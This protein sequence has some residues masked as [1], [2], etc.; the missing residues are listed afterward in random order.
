MRYH[1]L[2]NH[3]DNSGITAA[4]VKAL[5]PRLLKLALPHKRDLGIGL[6]ALLVASGINLL[7]PY[8]I[9]QALNGELGLNLMNDL[10]R[11]SLLL[12]ALF[13]VQACMFYVR[14]L[15]F[16]TAGYKVVADLRETLY[17]AMMSQ[18]VAFF[19]RSRVGDLMSRLSN[20]TQLMQNAVT[21]NVSVAIRFLLQVVGGIAL[22]IWISGKLTLVILAT[23]PIVM[24]GGRYWG[25]RLAAASRRMQAELGEA[26]VVAEESL[27]AV[28]IVR[29]YA[30]EKHETSRYRAAIQRALESGIT[31]TGIAAVFSSSMVFVIH[32]SIAVVLWYGGSLVLAQ[33]LTLAD[34]TAFILY[35]VI[36]AA[37]LG[38]LLSAFDEF[39]HALGASERIFEV[40][41]SRPTIA[42]PVNP[43]SIHAER[44]PHVS[45][46]GVSFSYPS[47]P[48]VEV[49]HDITFDVARGKTIAIVGPSGAG[50]TSIASLIPR[51]YDPQHGSI[52]YCGV[53][54]RQLDPEQLRNE[55]SFVT[56]DNLVFSVSIEEN[57]RYG[58]PDADDAEIR[59]AAQLAQL[60]TFVEGLPEKYRTLVGDRGVQLSGGE[61]QR[62]AIA[63]AI[64]KNPKLL[65]LDE[66]TSALDSENESLV[67]AA[68]QELMRG[69]TTIVIA[70]RLSSVQTADT[71]LVLKSGR[72]VQRGTHEQLIAV[73]GLYKTLVEFQVLN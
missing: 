2:P 63:R 35:G 41:D 48:D 11:F 56:Q 57:I 45:F 28:R 53:D 22:M 61:R 31:R 36:V 54:L 44:E 33:E 70:H 67:R 64:L 26:A 39:L 51:F 3:P 49:L 19:D 7:F 71:V 10:G 32:A 14:H 34:L 16:A 59:H 23:L 42:A 1:R 65:I 40:I 62:L 37:S 24:F 8:L 5:A 46:Q 55:I 4:K 69:R 9:R 66:A 43:S 21:V 13:L 27:G 30:G 50:K 6:A 60:S 47:R 25:K 38:F 18:D 58:K 68:M 29:M 12:I 20:D 72:I 15:S 17:R 52:D 73:E